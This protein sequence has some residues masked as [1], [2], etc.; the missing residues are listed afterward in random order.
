MR[1]IWPQ[2]LHSPPVPCWI[3]QVTAFGLVSAHLTPLKDSLYQ[4]HSGESVHMP[5]APKYTQAS[6]FLS[7][8]VGGFCGIFVI[9][10]KF[11]V[12]VFV[13]GKLCVKIVAGWWVSRRMT[14]EFFNMFTYDFV[15]ILQMH[16]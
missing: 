14:V 3:S 2:E 6:S 9:W 10:N 4:P 5:L 7:T 16:R 13:F 12:F 1:L 8:A 11:V 15:A